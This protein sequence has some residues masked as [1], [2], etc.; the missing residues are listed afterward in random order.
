MKT[1]EIQTAVLNGEILLVGTYFSGRVDRIS[2]RDKTPGA[3]GSRKD[4]LI[5]KEI[6]MTEKEPFTVSQFLP[7]ASQETERAWKPSAKKGD[8]V[9]VSLRTLQES[10]GNKSGDGKVMP[11][12]S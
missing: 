6:I 10:Y 12:Q 9:I 2:V 8:K 3:G 1:S 4:M 11:L 7:D 5:S